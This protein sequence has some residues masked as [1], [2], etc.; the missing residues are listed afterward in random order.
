MIDLPPPVT[1]KFYSDPVDAA[2]VMDESEVDAQRFILYENER[3]LLHGENIKNESEKK[4][5]IEQERL[6]LLANRIHRLLDDIALLNEGGYLSPEYEQLSRE[7]IFDV[8]D[9]F[10]IESI[11]A[12]CSTTPP[13]SFPDPDNEDPDLELEFG[14]YLGQQLW[15]LNTASEERVDF[16]KI[17]WG[18]MLGAF[19]NSKYSRNENERAIKDTI[20]FIDDIHKKR[21][22]QDRKERKKIKRRDSREMVVDSEG[23]AECLKSPQVPDHPSVPN[24]F[25]IYQIGLRMPLPKRSELTNALT[26]SIEVSL[27]D[28]QIC[29]QILPRI[30][31]S[32]SIVENKTWNKV[33][34]APVFQQVWDWCVSVNDDVLESKGRGYNNTITSKRV[35]QRYKDQMGK[36][37]NMSDKGTASKLL[38]DLSSESSVN[39]RY[40]ND[41]GVKIDLP[42]G[43]YIPPVVTEVGNRN[44][45]GRNWKLTSYG[46]LVGIWMFTQDGPE[47]V[48][49]CIAEALFFSD[50]QAR[51]HTEQL[52]GK[53]KSQAEIVKNVAEKIGEPLPVLGHYK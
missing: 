41:V 23:I 26:D 9:R 51:K 25:E 52:D 38:N 1:R 42:K 31:K 13:R 15:N 29:I 44:E 11:W 2:Y 47:T 48:I 28:A 7:D 46:T 49:D 4:K 20:D 27:E 17:I 10:N 43:A 3:R 40:F 19:S 32:V 5:K 18:I 50:S 12:P 36:D 22:E 33:Q 34:A 37:G 16:R 24:P 21:V 14:T 30:E 8:S 35:L 45:R 6:P 39:K 53:Q